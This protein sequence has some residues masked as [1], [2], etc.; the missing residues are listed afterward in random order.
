[1][2]PV[3]WRPVV[4]WAAPCSLVPGTASLVFCQAC[5]IKQA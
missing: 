5:H 1:M 3:V 4:P 2:V